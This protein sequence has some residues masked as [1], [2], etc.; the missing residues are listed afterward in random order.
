MAVIDVCTPSWGSKH[1]VK[2]PYLP[3]YFL[4]DQH[5]GTI[6][7]F[8]R[9]TD[10]LWPEIVAI[11]LVMGFVAEAAVVPRYNDSS[12]GMVFKRFEQLGKEC[13]R[14]VDIVVHEADERDIPFESDRGSEVVGVKPVHVATRLDM[15]DL[16]PLSSLLL[17][18]PEA[19]TVIDHDYRVDMGLMPQPIQQVVLLRVVDDGWNNNQNFRSHFR[20]ACLGAGARGGVWCTS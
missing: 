20:E 8:D 10:L 3:E 12:V 14:D 19:F 4:G 16:A 15:P 11:G 5:T 6:H 18:Y 17:R 2:Q 13:F 1:R 7:P 9:R